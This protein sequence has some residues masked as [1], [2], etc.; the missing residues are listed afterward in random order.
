[1]SDR[2]RVAALIED[3]A[4]QLCEIEATIEGLATE[5][6]R[7]EARIKQSRSTVK[8]AAYAKRLPVLRMG[9]LELEK[10]KLFY[11]NNFAELANG[12]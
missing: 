10:K 5:L 8:K 9:M 1:M 11:Q 6:A 7:T 2:D 4:L 12:N 3:F